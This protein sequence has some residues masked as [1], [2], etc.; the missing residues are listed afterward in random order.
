[1]EKSSSDSSHNLPSPKPWAFDPNVQIY[2]LTQ[3]CR[4]P[5]FDVEQ[6]MKMLSSML[7]ESKYS[8]QHENIKAVMDMYKTGATPDTSGPW[9]FVDGKFLEQEPVLR[10]LPYGCSLFVEVRFLFH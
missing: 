5:P 4:P 1:M 6:R 8:H 7:S 3:T 9:W 10:E 2:D